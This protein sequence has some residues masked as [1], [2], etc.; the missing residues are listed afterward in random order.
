V[1]TIPF[2]IFNEEE[3]VR[4]CLVNGKQKYYDAITDEEGRGYYDKHPNFK[5]VG[6]GIVYSINGILQ[7]DADTHIFF[8]KKDNPMLLNETS[9]P[10][11][12][13]YLRKIN[14]KRG[15]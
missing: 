12:S 8:V 5:Y 9:V 6:K 14:K 1:I 11:Y 10:T 3:P 2:R 13:D 15:R 4:I 7:S